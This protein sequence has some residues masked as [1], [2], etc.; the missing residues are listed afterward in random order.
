[1]K[2]SKEKDKE[3]EEEREREG[4]ECE[5]MAATMWSA[6]PK[7]FAIWPI[8]KKACQSVLQ[9]INMVLIFYN[10]LNILYIMA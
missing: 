5:D 2:K 7:I 4:E 10:L 8:K 9:K 6:K 1:M 3:A